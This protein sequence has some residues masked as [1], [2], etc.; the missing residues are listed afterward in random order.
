MSY[1][2]LA[3]LA[4]LGIAACGSDDD[5]VEQDSQRQLSLVDSQ[6]SPY[7]SHVRLY[8]TSNGLFA[9]ED[10]ICP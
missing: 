6:C 5:P 10:P 4:L 8:T 7:Q 2:P 9:I 3:L 1:V